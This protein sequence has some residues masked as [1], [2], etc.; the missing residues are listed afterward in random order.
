MTE[1]I[2]NRYDFTFFFDVSN[3]NPNGD[4]NND[5]IP[6][7]DYRDGHGLVTDVCLKRKV[8]NYIDLT[9]HGEEG[10]AIHIRQGSLLDKDIVD[11]EKDTGITLN[12]KT[13]PEEKEKIVK[14]LCDRFFDVRSFGA[15]IA[16]S[17]D[18]VC[19]SICGP[20]QLCMAKS[21]DIIEPQEISI[22][23]CAG[24]SAKEKEDGT[25]KTQTMG[26]KHIIPYALYKV[27]GSVLPH[28]AQRTGFSEEDLELFFEALKEM[29]YYDKSTSRGS[30]YPRGLYVFKHPGNLCSAPLHTLFE[31]I[32]IKRNFNIDEGP[33]QFSDYEISH[34]AASM[35]NT[36]I[37]VMVS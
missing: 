33:R 26:R 34:D 16:Y 11:I 25:E 31:S 4:P 32:N 14:A 7:M 17:K 19:K 30:M 21:L 1:V 20:I 27:E 6:R 28:F 23:R 10:K 9:R 24:S 3:G 36:D 8:R 12:K 2:K 35:T 18:H 15:V 22:T 13:Q 5:N 29:F 37:N